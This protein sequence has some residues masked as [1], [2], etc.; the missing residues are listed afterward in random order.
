MNSVPMLTMDIKRIWAM[1]LT[2][3]YIK[4]LRDSILLSLQ[5]V[6]RA[7]RDITGFLGKTSLFMF[8]KIK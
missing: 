2:R 1:E 3:D 8:I 6:I 4:E 7:N 5:L